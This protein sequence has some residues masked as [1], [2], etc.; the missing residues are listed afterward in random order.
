[1]EITKE[2]FKCKVEQPLSS[3]YKHKQMGD[4]HLNKC[5]SCNKADTKSR[6]EKMKMDPDWVEK[7]KTRGREKYHRLGNKKPSY[8]AKKAAMQ[9]YLS[10]Y[11]EK[12]KARN[13]AQRISENG[14]DSHHWSYNEIHWKD[15]ISMTIKDHMKAHRFIV[16]DQERMMYRRFDT[17][18]LLDTRE[19][20]EEFIFDCVENKPD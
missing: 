6:I 17:N 13:A 1:M 11:P 10:K 16:Y 5:I 9:R 14:N 15:V 20:H 2:C 19:K 3:F 4:G 7:E 18:E 8:E 12:E